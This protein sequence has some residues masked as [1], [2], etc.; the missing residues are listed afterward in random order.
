MSHSCLSV[1]REISVNTSVVPASPQRRAHRLTE[2]GR[3]PHGTE[4]AGCVR[5]VISGTR[6]K[7]WT[8]RAPGA[9]RSARV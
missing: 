1:A 9:K 5:E 7:L 3:P 8:S 6:P 4:V 2:L